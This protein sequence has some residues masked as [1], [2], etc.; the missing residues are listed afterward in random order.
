MQ[1][2]VDIYPVPKCLN[3]RDNPGHQLAQ[4]PA[5]VFKKSRSILGMVKLT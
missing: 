5:V 1:M 4:N 2:R 3:G